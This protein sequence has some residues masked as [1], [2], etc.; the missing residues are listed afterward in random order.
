MSHGKSGTGPHP[1]PATQRV[2][3]AVYGR[4]GVRAGAGLPKRAMCALPERS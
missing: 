1:H 2:H 3:T 4:V